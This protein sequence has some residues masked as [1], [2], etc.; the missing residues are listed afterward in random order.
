MA[1][2]KREVILKDEVEV[3]ELSKCLAVSLDIKSESIK[4]D[5]FVDKK[6]AVGWGKNPYELT[7]IKKKYYYYGDKF[8]AQINKSG[9]YGNDEI[10]KLL[11][12]DKI[13]PMDA[14]K[15]PDFNEDN[16]TWFDGA[17]YL[18][19]RL[20]EINPISLPYHRDYIGGIDNGEYNLEKVLKV[21][22]ENPNI[23][24]IKEIRIPYYN[25]DSGKTRAIEFVVK[26][27]QETHDV[28]CNHYRDVRKEK[29]WTVRIKD[30]I[31][32]RPW[33]KEAYGAD[34]DVLGIKD[35]YDKKECE[36][37]DEED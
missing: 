23:S 20:G 1:S 28:F 32:W 33:H 14:I 34:F 10:W 4:G 9:F 15:L 37:E 17:S 12:S 30:C 35:C 19:Y 21:L 24:Q 18:L 6:D 7:E 3:I 13:N 22:K 29:F 11:D 5:F 26:L 16:L 31:V 8:W 36:N 2:F 27:P 25:Q